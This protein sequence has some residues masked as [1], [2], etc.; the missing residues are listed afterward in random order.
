MSEYLSVPDTTRAGVAYRLRYGAVE[1]SRRSGPM[2]SLLFSLAQQA[3]IWETE[4]KNV[5]LMSCHLTGDGDYA[6][7]CLVEPG[8][9]R[10]RDSSASERSPAFR[11]AGGNDGLEAKIEAA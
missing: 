5:E 10:D 1:Y 2:S 7:F 3:L 8:E 4:G 6:G 9:L 11:S